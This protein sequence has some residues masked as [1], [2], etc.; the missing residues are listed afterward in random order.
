MYNKKINN[1]NENREYKEDKDVS[2][3]NNN[4]LLYKYIHNIRNSKT[5]S[6]DILQNINNFCYEDRMKI[7]IAY[8][9]MN[10][11]YLSLFEDNE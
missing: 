9:E 10:G 11:Y 2:N 4:Q 6:M 5:F 7:L 3:Y 8:N 1:N